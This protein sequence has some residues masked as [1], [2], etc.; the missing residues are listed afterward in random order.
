MTEV[1]SQDEIDQLLTA[2]STG[3]VEGDEAIKKAEARKIKIYD[4]KR[5]DKFSKDQIRTLQMM[6]ETF[7]RLT[8][9]SLSA[10]LRAI[11][12]VH[13]AS[14]DQLTYEEFL[15]SIPN[16]TTLAVI[17]MDPL[18]G[19][20]IL[21]IDP[22]ITF[23]VIDRLFGGPGEAA[24]INRELTDI[25]LS[26]IEGI[27][28]RILGNL[29]EAWSNVIDLRPRLGNIETNPQ[30][31][32]I[33]PPSDMVVLITLETKV[34]DV[35]GM[36]NFCIPYLTIE[37]IISK[38]SAQYWYSSIRKGGTSEN[39]AI[40][41]QRLETVM[42][43]IEAELGGLDITVRDVL[44]LAK[45]D[46]IKLENTKVTDEMELKIGTM[47]KFYARPGVVGNHLAVQITKKIESYKN[48]SNLLDEFEGGEL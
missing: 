16:P 22:S 30:F 13:V 38:L 36:T 23:T 11:V 39:L 26:V 31:A 44:N 21:E 29:R 43:N 46:I 8:T 20:S 15:R 48:E 14:V 19:S 35:E 42:V 34:G 47:K 32:Q 33:V 7:A 40:L 24:K 37:P 4:F 17:N 12:S 6:H 28:V 5:P 9:T 25:E 41:K 2:I 45:G 27:I 1:L 18:K 3:E 10:Q